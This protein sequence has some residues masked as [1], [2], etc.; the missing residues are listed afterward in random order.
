MTLA[1]H[2]LVECY[3]VLTRLPRPHRMAPGPVLE[4][5]RASFVDR[6]TVVALS[7]ERYLELLSTVGAAGL[8]G[9]RVYDAVIA[10]CARE[11]KA[12]VLLTFNVRDFTGL[13]PGLDV[14][15]PAGR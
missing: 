14:C 10:A 3:S 5:I 7:S 9:G 12:D 8:P 1:A 2:S 4:L 13:V 6:G 11:A 15:E